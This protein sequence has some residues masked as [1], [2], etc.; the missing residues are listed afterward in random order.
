MQS[1]VSME[2]PET[3]YISPGVKIG[4]DTVIFPNSFIL[5]NSSIGE[6][7]TIGP[8]AYLKD[9]VI[10]NNNRIRSSWVYN[11]EIGDDQ[12]IHSYQVIENKKIK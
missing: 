10:G 5:G 12:E 6:R 1:G 8:N 11:C 4:Q 2:D 7:N 3:T 9:V